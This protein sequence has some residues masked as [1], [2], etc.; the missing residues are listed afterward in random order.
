MNRPIIIKHKWW[1]FWRKS[2]FGL[3]PWRWDVLGK[4]PEGSEVF[5]DGYYE[6]SSLFE[7]SFIIRRARE[8]PQDGK[9]IIEFNDSQEY[10]AE[11]VKD[12]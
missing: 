7:G 8:A 3:N 1:R 4:Y 9:T 12:L 10:H 2:Y 6:P 5:V 11:K